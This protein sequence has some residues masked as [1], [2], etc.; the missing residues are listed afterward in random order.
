MPE[1]S[2]IKIC[3]MG[4]HV[5]YEL[6]ASGRIYIQTLN[7]INIDEYTKDEKVGNHN[8]KVIQRNLIGSL[9]HDIMTE[10]HHYQSLIY[11]IKK[12]SMVSTLTANDFIAVEE[13]TYEI[14]RLELFKMLCTYYGLS[15]LSDDKLRII[16]TGYDKKEEDPNECKYTSGKDTKIRR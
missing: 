7:E 8:L 4:V 6:L 9:M 2:L 16:I 13:L 10:V 12:S 11:D 14:Y 15:S 1:F 3:K 5:D